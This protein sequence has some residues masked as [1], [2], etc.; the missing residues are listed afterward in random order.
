M[1]N[2][3]FFTELNPE[4]L[5]KAMQE[6]NNSGYE[7]TNIATR[8]MDNEF[9]LFYKEKNTTIPTK[10]DLAKN[11]NLE[12][13]SNIQIIPNIGQEKSY[14]DY[15]KQYWYVIAVAIGIAIYYFL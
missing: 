1:D 7:I 2:F 13:N 6:L 10:E 8:D 11:V 4:N 3:K 9:I 5:R 14:M 12:P 15:A